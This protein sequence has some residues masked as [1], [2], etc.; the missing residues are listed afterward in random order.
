MMN[1]VDDAIAFAERKAEEAT[2]THREA[3]SLADTPTSLLHLLDRMNL[4]EYT[5][6]IATTNKPLSTMEK[7]PFTRYVRPGRFDIHYTAMCADGEAYTVA[8]PTTH[9]GAC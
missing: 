8:A 3:T 7:D 9:L 6:V 4:M 2:N 1:E 5:I